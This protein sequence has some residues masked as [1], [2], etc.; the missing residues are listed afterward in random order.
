MRYVHAEETGAAVG[1]FIPAQ[2]AGKCFDRAYDRA[3]ELFRSV[4]ISRI[5]PWLRF[6]SALAWPRT[7]HRPCPCPEYPW[8]GLTVEDNGRL[9]RSHFERAARRKKQQTPRSRELA[10]V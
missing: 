1:V 8:P 5:G 3:Q 2:S 10:A 6:A 9:S 7:T 4:E